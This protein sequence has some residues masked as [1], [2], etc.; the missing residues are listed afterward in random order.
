MQNHRKAI[1]SDKSVQSY[2]P[3]AK[4]YHVPL[5]NHPKL[6][7]RVRPNG[8]KSWIYRYKHPISKKT[9]QI[10]FGI[11][12][13]TSLKRA[14][15]MWR[16]NEDL[17][18]RQIN[19]KTYK[20]EQRQFALEKHSN[21]FADISAEWQTRQSDVKKVSKSTQ[22]GNE[23]YL[24]YARAEFGD[25]PITEITA[26]MVLSLCEQWEKKG[27]YETAN[28]IKLKCSQVFRY[29]AIQG[30]CQ[31]D[32]T[33]T[34]KGVLVTPKAKH[35]PSI[36]EPSQF[37]KLLQDIDTLRTGADVINSLKLLALLYPRYGDLR[38]AKW[39]DFDLNAAIW[40]LK[41]KK[42]DGRKD[43]IKEVQL[44][45]PKQAISILQEQ[46]KLTGYTEYVFYS[47]RAKK[48]HVISE[49]TA[50]KA[51]NKAGYQG[52]HCPHGFRASA[53]TMQMEQLGYNDALTELQLAHKVRDIHGTAY[54][55]V[56]FL[57]ER[58]AMAQA[59]ADYL[60]ELKNS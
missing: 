47:S 45:L 48:E 12:P 54:N 7:L 60:D 41:P 46:K 32:V 31:Y 8:T 23:R 3:K 15:E 14:C 27:N 9:V 17:L 20:D 2:K 56:A 6:F 39:S 52:I 11:Y 40:T 10:S 29:A 1:K 51:L 30:K 53:K 5:D 25:K 38:Y 35:Y 19:P 21:T 37:G 4:E 50:G 22:T 58:R 44:P 57:D 49:N 26:P 13:N 28:R 18:S 59:W 24:S 16:D 33:T 34:L 36:I 55:R 43:M 42:G